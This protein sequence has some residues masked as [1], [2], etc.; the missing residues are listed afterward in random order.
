M[1]KK[2]PMENTMYPKF[3]NGDDAMKYFAELHDIDLAKYSVTTKLKAWLGTYY[4][5]YKFDV[6]KL[7]PVLVDKYK[8]VN[9]EVNFQGPKGLLLSLIDGN[10]TMITCYP[11][12]LRNYDVAVSFP[13]RTY[14]E[15]SVQEFGLGDYNCGLSACI[16]AH[17]TQR[18]DHDSN[19]VTFIDL[20][21]NVRNLFTDSGAF[22][23]E[24]EALRKKV[25]LI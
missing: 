5:V 23:R 17:Q 9:M 16:Q 4:G 22:S 21:G 10:A 12:Q 13:Q 6:N 24:C 8:L 7:N 18:P 11:V 25:A 14:F 20:W 3:V 15:R 19:D 1:S 2:M